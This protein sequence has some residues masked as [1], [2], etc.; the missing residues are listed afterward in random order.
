MTDRSQTKEIGIEPHPRLIWIVNHKTLLPA[1]VPILRS[2]VL[3][4]RFLR[5]E[6]RRK[7]NNFLTHTF[8]RDF[9]KSYADLPM[10]SLKC[11]GKRL[12]PSV[13]RVVSGKSL[14]IYARQSSHLSAIELEE[15]HVLVWDPTAALRAIESLMI[16]AKGYRL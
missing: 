5:Q 6:Y 2:P 10:K 11:W 15:N 13:E 3:R 7:T 9:Q 14:P 1:E 12:S 4:R 16:A 8:M